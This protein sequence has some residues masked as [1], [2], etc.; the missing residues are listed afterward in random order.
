MRLGGITI[1]KQEWIRVASVNIL[2]SRKIKG[3]LSWHIYSILWQPRNEAKQEWIQ[4]TSF[5]LLQPI[6]IFS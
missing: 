4:F 6:C 1:Y 3:H 5:L 2:K